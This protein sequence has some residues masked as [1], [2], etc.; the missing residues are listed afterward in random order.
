MLYTFLE[1][2]TYSKSSS[3]LSPAQAQVVAALATGL[4]VT[5]AASAAGVHRSTVHNWR[6]SLPAFRAAVIESRAK[7]QAQ[8]RDVTKE[9]P[10]LAL[11]TLHDLL[12]DPKATHSV[13][14]KAALA[15]LGRP[16]GFSKPALNR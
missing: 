9:L 8:F 3:E 12:K 4:N 1:D 16:G 13:R 15:V 10:V 6:N 7:F 14:L 5:A 2:T 11:V